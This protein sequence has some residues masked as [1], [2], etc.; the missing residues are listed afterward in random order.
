LGE[1]ELVIFGYDIET[2][3]LDP[4]APGARMLTF[5]W[6][7]GTRKAQAR[8]PDAG[9]D[10]ALR[11]LLRAPAAQCVGHNLG[12]DIPWTERVFGTR[13]RCSLFDT[14]IAQYRLDENVPN[15]LEDTAQR[16][17]GE[18][19]LHGIDRRKLEDEPI[20]KVLAYNARDAVLAYRLYK[21]LAEALAKEGLRD[22]F[23]LDMRL[24]RVL[25]D[26]RHRGVLVDWKALAKINKGTEAEIAKLERSLVRRAGRNIN[27][28]SNKQ[29]ADLLVNK[30][31]V[32]IVKESKKTGAPSFDK[33]ALAFLRTEPGLTTKEKKWLA[34]FGRCK[35]LLTRKSSFMD[36]WP[37][38]KGVDGRIHTTFNLG[39]AEVERRGAG[40][41]SAM[42]GTVTGRLSSSE[43]NLQNVPKRDTIL[44]PCFVPARGWKL[45]KGD[46]S[47]IE[48]RVAGWLSG[49]PAM[50]GIFERGEDFHT[51][52][53]AQLEG[54]AYEEAVKRVKAQPAWSRKRDACKRVN[55]GSIYGAW[56]E[57]IW[58]VART[59]G[60]DV[61]LGEIKEVWE[62]QHEAFPGFWRWVDV[63]RFMAERDGKVTSPFGAV[64]RLPAAQGRGWR[65]KGEAQRQ[66]VNHLVQNAAL[67]V[68]RRA[69][70]VIERGA[71]P[72]F[73]TV[74]TVHDE[75][76]VEYKGWKK[77]T[78]ESLLRS[79]MVD[80]VLVWMREEG[81]PELEH[82]HLAATVEAG[83]ARWGAIED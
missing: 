15:K 51:A 68:L 40:A 1:P 47:Q 55:F 64:R 4:Y 27:L 25:I 23:D 59:D 2:N 48:L 54:L 69:L 30:W 46:Y 11:V 76:V 67:E 71:Q 50:R 37:E 49:D 65:E 35:D 57:R 77:A 26:L 16:W 18:G 6:A 63:V 19:K 81:I 75:V 44:R 74:L 41:R 10:P 60:F 34:D 79:C 29:L 38:H 42:K 28:R 9:C 52:T 53:L 61:T 43:P 3:K 31:D 66:A 7:E 12:F 24:L 58:R 82:L 73:R 45:A 32:P 22:L 5:A 36:K 8:K 83:L 13:V 20:D 21:P 17:L 72:T 70:L 78:M 14:M 33:E 62:K 80:D 39:R 56:P